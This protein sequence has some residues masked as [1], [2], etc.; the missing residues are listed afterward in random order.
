[1][2]NDLAA[3]STNEEPDIDHYKL[4]NTIGQGSFAKVRLA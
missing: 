3:I 2:S 1:M 4:L